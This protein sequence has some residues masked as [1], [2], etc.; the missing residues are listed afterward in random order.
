LPL[1]AEKVEEGTRVVV[2]EKPTP[3][4]T[5]AVQPAET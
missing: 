5:E 2:E 1:V 3:L 4:L